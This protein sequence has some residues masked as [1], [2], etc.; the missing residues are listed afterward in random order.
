MPQDLKDKNAPQ[1][2]FFWHGQQADGAFDKVMTLRL[3][4]DRGGGGAGAPVAA[5]GNST[6]PRAPAA[7]RAPGA[8]C[9]I[10]LARGV[11]EMRAAMA[12]RGARLARGRGGAPAAAR[13]DST[14]QRTR[15]AWGPMLDWSLRM[16]NV[17][18]DAVRRALV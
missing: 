17:W 5:R 7:L 16:D 9:G 4:S 1:L 10:G 3:A 6:P 15:A 11:G 14:L 12:Q 2:T 13:G 18:R 8:P